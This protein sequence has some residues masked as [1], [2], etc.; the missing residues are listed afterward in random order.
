MKLTV[1]IG[2]VIAAAAIPA[3]AH[4][5]QAVVTCNPSGGYTVTPDYQQLN[6]TWTISP[7]GVTVTWGDGYSR[8][9]PLPGDCPAP[10]VQ[11]VPPVVDVPDEQPAPVMH[12]GPVEPMPPKKP[13]VQRKPKPRKHARV[14][15]CSFVIKHYR[16]TARAR[17]IMTH[18]L[19]KTCGRPFNPP[20]TG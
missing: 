3:T 14:V 4:A 16:G 5:H 20:V 13:T 12:P 10:P 15:T 17:M 11:P 7:V 2:S 1:I 8:T 18:R 6:P 9:F 19:P